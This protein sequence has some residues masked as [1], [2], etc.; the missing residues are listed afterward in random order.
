MRGPPANTLLQNEMEELEEQGRQARG[1]LEQQVQKL[2]AQATEAA[3]H[4]RNKESL[5]NQIKELAAAREAERA[6]ANKRIR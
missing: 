2:Q 1:L 5:N 4:L 6:A 3:A